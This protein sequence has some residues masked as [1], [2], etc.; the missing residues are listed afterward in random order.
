MNGLPEPDPN[1]PEQ[2]P[3]TGEVELQGSFSAWPRIH[4]ADDCYNE[5]DMQ[6]TAK[7]K[8][9]R[10]VGPHVSLVITNADVRLDQDPMRD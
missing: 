1:P 10:K 2:E 6:L 5:A 3:L 4:E 9:L 7:N 8:V